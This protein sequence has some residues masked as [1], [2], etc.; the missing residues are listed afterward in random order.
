VRFISAFLFRHAKTQYSISE[1]NTSNQQ[2][3]ISAGGV[4]LY[5]VATVIHM[6]YPRRYRT[7]ILWLQ[8]CRNELNCRL[9]QSASLLFTA[10]DAKSQGSEL[11][12]VDNSDQDWKVRHYRSDWVD[13]AHSSDIAPGCFEIGAP[14][15]LE[16][17][18]RFLGF[19][20]L[21]DERSVRRSP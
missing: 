13:L 4:G 14:L 7:S 19:E 3:I 11:F 21:R 12:L 20:E 2:P 9:G 15:V 6:R 8:F 18:S 17:P 10:S 1:Q 5:Y 16:C